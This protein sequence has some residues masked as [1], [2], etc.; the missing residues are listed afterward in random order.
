VVLQIWLRHPRDYETAIQEAIL[1]G[2]DT[3]T[4]AAILGGMVG[5]GCGVEGIPKKW[6]DSIIEWPRSV[7][8][9]N[10]LALRLARAKTE[11]KKYKPLAINLLG[12][13]LRNAFFMLWVLLHGFRRLLP[14]Y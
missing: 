7:S 3:D 14:P 4:V 13:L 8:W 2:G 12:I 10:A 11:N 9:M 1:C 5:A 6:I